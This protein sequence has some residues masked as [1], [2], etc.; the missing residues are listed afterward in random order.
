LSCGDSPF[1]WPARRR[2][3]AASAPVAR[4]RTASIRLPI[5]AGPS[6]SASRGVAHIRPSL[7]QDS[8]GRGL[9]AVAIRTSTVPLR[10]ERACT[11]GARVRGGRGRSHRAC[12]P[13]VRTWREPAG[14]ERSGWRI[15]LSG[16]RPN[17]SDRTFRSSPSGN[18]GCFGASID[19]VRTQTS[20]RKR[21][22]TPFTQQGHCEALSG[23]ALDQ[24]S[25]AGWGRSAV[26]APADDFP[27]L[28]TAIG[29][30][31]VTRHELGFPCDRAYFHATARPGGPCANTSDL[32]VTYTR[33][34]GTP[35]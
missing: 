7:G 31:K 4:D 23:H 26:S 29:T 28:H 9:V 27:R 19:C 18:G 34:R 22:R 8:F 13:G 15:R 35:K 20:I 16:P 11:R 32:H 10:L 1:L 30:P 14:G 24:L 33:S 12:C 21:D 2:R 6:R 3:N 5:T 17:G 25:E